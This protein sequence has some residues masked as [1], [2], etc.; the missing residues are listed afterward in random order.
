MERKFVRD[1]R[2]GVVTRNPAKPDKLFVHRAIRGG[3]LVDMT[4]VI[5]VGKDGSWTVHK[6]GPGG[7]YGR[8]VGKL[9]RPVDGVSIGS[10]DC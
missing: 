8:R 10:C 7:R 1:I 4:Y 3:R 6:A 2:E 5:K 9:G